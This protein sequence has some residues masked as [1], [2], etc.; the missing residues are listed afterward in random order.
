[1]AS[2][3][4]IITTITKLDIHTIVCSPRPGASGQLGGGGGGGDLA[5]QQHLPLRLPSL[6][7]L[8]P[9]QSLHLASQVGPGEV[10][11][12]DLPAARTVRWSREDLWAGGVEGQALQP[13]VEQQPAGEESS[14]SEAKHNAGDCRL[15]GEGH[16]GQRILPGVCQLI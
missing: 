9:C 8:P 16:S 2:S 13:Q 12:G 3:I 1:M 15:S 5:H 10:S 7:L 11:T 6:V 4:L 14:R